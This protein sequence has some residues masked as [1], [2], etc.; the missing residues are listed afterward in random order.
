V[1]RPRDW[2]GGHAVRA[3]LEGEVLEGLWFDRTLE[4]MPG[5]VRH[6]VRG[7]RPRGWDFESD[8]K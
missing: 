8:A 1:E 3:L 4:L 6:G 5:P 7:T 2:P